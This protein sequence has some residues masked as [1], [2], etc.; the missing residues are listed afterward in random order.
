MLL[1]LLLRLQDPAAL[2]ERLGSDDIEV[3]QRAEAELIRLGA[4]AEPALEQGSR[5]ADREIAGRAERIL[6]EVVA[7]HRREA[8]AELSH[9]LG[10][11]REGVSKRDRKA[12]ERLLGALS[13]VDPGHPLLKVSAAV[14]TGPWESCFLSRDAALK[15][16]AASNAFTRM[17]GREAWEAVRE[18]YREAVAATPSPGPCAPCARWRMSA[19]K[20]GLKF[21]NAKA[22]D[23][24]AYLRDVGNIHLIVD[25]MVSDEAREIDLD[26]AVT[27][28]AKDLTLGEALDRVL[29]PCGLEAVV[30]PEEGVVLARRRASPR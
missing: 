4:T 19:V 11:L 5:H 26:R 1:A 13:R 24:L 3:R 15:E 23:I 18:T 28:E 25:A 12:V 17:P 20:V 8:A 2:V 21:E 10:H 9:L 7:P 6:L 30:V 29:A 27:I 14:A 16:V 22:I